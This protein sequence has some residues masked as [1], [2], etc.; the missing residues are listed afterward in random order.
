MF[1]NPD[2]RAELQEIREFLCFLKG[3]LSILAN[4]E[5][6]QTNYQALSLTHRQKA[7][8]AQHCLSCFPLFQG[9]INRL[10]ESLPIEPP[11]E[12]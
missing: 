3:N 11:S 5:E 12:F 10:I 2:P 4:D 6:F 8:V 7:K 9:K 1:P